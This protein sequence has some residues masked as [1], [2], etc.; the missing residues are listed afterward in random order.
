MEAFYQLLKV[1]Q[2]IADQ[3]PESP[4]NVFVPAI[5]NNAIDTIRMWH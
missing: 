4:A 3:F 1:A 2:S 5:L